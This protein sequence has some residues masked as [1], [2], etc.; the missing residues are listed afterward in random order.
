MSAAANLTLCIESTH[1]ALP[2]HFPGMPVVPG[3]VL[4]SRILAEFQQRWP[5]VQPAG[6]RKLKF[7]K[8][9]LPGQPFTV[10]FSAPDTHAVRFKCWQQAVLLAEGNL[11]LAHERAA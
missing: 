6:I 7:L 2:G 8:L 10:E 5:Q 4:L 1:P 9:L 3:V 11:L